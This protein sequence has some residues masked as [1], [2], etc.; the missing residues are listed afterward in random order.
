M[1][2]YAVLR[3]LDSSSSHYKPLR[4]EIIDGKPVKVSDVVVHQITISDVEDPD[5][6]V[7]EPMCAWQHSESG[8]WVMANA[9]EKP[10]WVRQI[11]ISTYGYLYLIVARLKESDQIFWRLK[12]GGHNK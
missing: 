12:W 10:Y 5:L 1:A 3:D 7:A 4:V 11:D 6:L 8:Q 9:V 2:A